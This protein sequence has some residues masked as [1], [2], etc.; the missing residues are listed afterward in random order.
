MVE[1]R[2][3]AQTQKRDRMTSAV[4]MALCSDEENVAQPEKFNGSVKSQTP[5]TKPSTSVTWSEF[6][7]QIKRVERLSRD[8]V[9]APF[10]QEMQILLPEKEFLGA[11]D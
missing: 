10:A 11:L 7:C 9:F 5:M 4:N 2:G 1:L 6:G 3:A 8:E